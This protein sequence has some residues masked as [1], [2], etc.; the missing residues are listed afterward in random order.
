MNLYDEVVNEVIE[1]ADRVFEPTD[2]PIT[3]LVNSPLLAKTLAH[4]GAGKSLIWFLI[5]HVYFHGRPRR[6]A[7]QSASN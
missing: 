4:L 5:P 6:N 3:V 2:T 1:F 7:I